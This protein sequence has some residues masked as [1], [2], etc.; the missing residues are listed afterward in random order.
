[1][2]KVREVIAYRNYFEDFLRKQPIKIQNK[3][4]KVIEIIETFERIPTQ[5]LK[6][7]SGHLGFLKQELN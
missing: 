6:Y 5:Y 4:Y 1:M 7:I 2:K 3:I